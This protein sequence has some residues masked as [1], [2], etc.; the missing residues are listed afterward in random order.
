MN[1]MVMS[2]HKETIYKYIRRRQ[3]R[4]QIPPF[5]IW[6]YRVLVVVVIVVMVLVVLGVLVVCA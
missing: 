5:P 3:W 1:K 2:S 4:M 6:D